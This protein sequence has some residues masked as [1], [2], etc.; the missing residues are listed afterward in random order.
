MFYQ[1]ACELRD[2]E[3]IILLNDISALRPSSGYFIWDHLD[4]KEQTLCG[5]TLQP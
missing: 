2:V 5:V 4:H 1:Y 3:K